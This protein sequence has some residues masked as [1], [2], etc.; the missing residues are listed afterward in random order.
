MHILKC[1]LEFVQDI[2]V[3]AIGVQGTGVQVCK[4]SNEHFEG[5]SGEGYHVNTVGHGLVNPKRPGC[6]A[7]LTQALSRFS[8]GHGADNQDA[9]SILVVP[10]LIVNT[11]FE[12]LLCPG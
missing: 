8:K 1:L 2:G 7:P 12:H 6:F 3:Q 9:D 5:R 10:T 11:Y 4:Y